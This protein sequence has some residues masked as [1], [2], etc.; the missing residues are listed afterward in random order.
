MSASWAGARTARSSA[1]TASTSQL[2][3][4]SDLFLNGVI[5]SYFYAPVPELPLCSSRRDSY[6]SPP[7]ATVREAPRSESA[8][9]IELVA[10]S[11]IL[12]LTRS[13]PPE[14]KA[15][16]DPDPLTPVNLN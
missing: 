14:R 1:W 10:P 16:G 5:L 9:P 4:S 3:L 13:L 2:P 15:L 6:A 8:P 12:R 7:D 11:A